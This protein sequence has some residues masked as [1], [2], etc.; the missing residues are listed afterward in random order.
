MQEAAVMAM[1]NQALEL[2]AGGKVTQKNAWAIEAGTCL[3]GIVESVT[4]AASFTRASAILGATGEAYGRKVDGLH[5]EILRAMTKTAE[6][7]QDT[8]AGTHTCS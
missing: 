1:Q 2:S 6:T 5:G 3:Q 4:D 7:A 8:A